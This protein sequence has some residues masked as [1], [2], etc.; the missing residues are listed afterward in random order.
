MRACECEC[1]RCVCERMSVS[2][3]PSVCECE[4]AEHHDALPRVD[5]EYFSKGSDDCAH[6]LED[7]VLRCDFSPNWY[8]GS[9]RYHSKSEQKWRDWL[10]VY[11]NERT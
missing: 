7:S 8:E 5:T 4:C 9:V 3:C 6:G 10:S 1:V 11:G 2:E